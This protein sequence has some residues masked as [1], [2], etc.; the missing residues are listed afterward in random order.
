MLIAER[1]AAALPNAQRYIV[2]GGGGFPLW[3]YPKLVNDRVRD[4]LA[5]NFA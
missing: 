3:E 2:P 4:F 1:I 5:Q